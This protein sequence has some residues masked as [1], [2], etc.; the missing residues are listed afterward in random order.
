MTLSRSF[1][2]L[3]G[4]TCGNYLYNAAP[5]INASRRYSEHL[6]GNGWR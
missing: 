3:I 6:L 4:D 5:Y 1:Y 2:T